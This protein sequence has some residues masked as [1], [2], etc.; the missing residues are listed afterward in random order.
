MS[1]TLAVLGATLGLFLGMLLFMELGWR[2]GRAPRSAAHAESLNLGTVEAAVFALLGLLVA[3]TFSGA[4]SR[5]EARHQM[6]VNEVTAISTAWDRLDFLPDSLEQPVRDEFLAFI[7]A[8]VRVYNDFG[9]IAK[10]QSALDSAAL[11]GHRLWMLAVY[12]S[13]HGAPQA[14]MLVLPAINAM[15]DMALTRV[16]AADLHTPPAIYI[17]LAFIALACSLQI[18]FDMGRAGRRSWFH[19]LTF[20]TCVVVAVYLIIDLEFPRQGLVRTDAFD[21]PLREVRRQL[22]AP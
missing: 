17:V 14:P 21:R 13:Q 19:M 4:A 11:H 7:D 15:R 3:F 9:N 16:L 6:V 20:S 22:T 8:R 12:A 2:I 18:G 5:F 1:L 10:R